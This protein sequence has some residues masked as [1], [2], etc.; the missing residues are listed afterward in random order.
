MTNQV[1]ENE[2]DLL[3][4]QANPE[5]ITPFSLKLLEIVK[6]QFLE[7][8]GLQQENAELKSRLNQ[9]SANSSRPPSSDGYRKISKIIQKEGTKRQGGQINHKGGTLRQEEK[10]DK[11]ELC[12]PTKCNCGHEFTNASKIVSFQKKQLFE[13]PV[14]KI[15]VTE[16]QV[17]ECKCP[18][19]GAMNQGKAPDNIKAPVQY[20][21]MAKSLAVLL[22]NDFKLPVAKTKQIFKILY[23]CA[24]NESVIQ[25][26]SRICYDKL[27][28]TEAITKEKLLQALVAYVDESG[29]RIGKKL[30][31]LHVFSS[32]PK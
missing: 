10:P 28:K 32:L 20:G 29:I 2:I 4:A 30:N 31:W 18:K 14:P 15:Y 1:A 27:E 17:I 22:T 6:R 23:G 21:N 9:N 24:M 13:I 25:S 19:C 26:S 5:E 3:L 7:I 12:Y 11:I 8:S 16:Y